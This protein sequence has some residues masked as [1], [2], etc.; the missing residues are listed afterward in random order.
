MKNK[1]VDLM[2][3]LVVNVENV[4][5]V[6]PTDNGN[7]FYVHTTTSQYYKIGLDGYNAIKDT[8]SSFVVLNSGLIIN[9]NY[10]VGVQPCNDNEYYIHTTT[11]QYYKI[12]KDDYSSLLQ[13]IF[14]PIDD[15]VQTKA[16]IRLSK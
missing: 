2:N 15:F 9:K 11:T 1:F 5:G 7:E 10:I 8:N 6:Q 16:G 4:I 14:K 13:V 12:N 3:G